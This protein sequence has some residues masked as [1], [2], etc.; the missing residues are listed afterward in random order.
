MQVS[1]VYARP[2]RAEAG[3]IFRLT[4]LVI[5]A[6]AAATM[7]LGAWDDGL[8]LGT[9][10][11]VV[12]IQLLAGL[13]AWLGNRDMEALGLAID[14]VVPVAPNVNPVVFAALMAGP[15]L[16]MASL[17]ALVIGDPLVAKLLALIGVANAGTALVIRRFVVTPKEGARKLDRATERRQK[18]VGVIIGVGLCAL[19]I[20]VA[21]MLDS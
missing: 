1:T 6:S 7:A 13:F 20:G 4:A 16:I 19:A 14:E 3:R 18:A 9:L 2:Y 15:L 12:V 17:S 21:T 11:G 10:A 5:A 8:I